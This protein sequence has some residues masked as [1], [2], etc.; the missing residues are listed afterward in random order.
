MVTLAWL[1]ALVPATARADAEARLPDDSSK[2]P[3]AGSD[4]P[5][6]LTLGRYHYDG[7]SAGSDINLRYRSGPWSG[8]LGVY[9]DRDFGSQW[10]AGLERPFALLD[11]GP[12]SLQLSIQLASRGFVGGSLTLEY[13]EPWFLLAGLGRTNNRPYFN[14]N[15]DPNDAFSVGAGWRGE[16]GLTAY[17]LLV[18]DNRFNPGQ[19]NLHG[20]LRLPLPDRQRLTLDL[21]NKRDPAATAGSPGRAV[22]LTWEWRDWSVRLADDRRQNFSE[23]NALR[24]SLAY[25]F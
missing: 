25:R 20:V 15:F 8:W 22:S 5:F 1:M 4:R 7:S 16:R 17:V 11:D 19:Q 3:Q 12:L 6:K 13:G 10:R 14:L 9:Q 21:Q 24:L 18:R 2:A 23:V